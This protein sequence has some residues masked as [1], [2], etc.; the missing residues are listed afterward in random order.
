MAKFSME[1]IPWALTTRYHGSVEL[2]G[3]ARN[4]EPTTRAAR[5][6]DAAAAR[7]P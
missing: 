5:G 6:V 7:A 4:S 1:I 2:R 3:N